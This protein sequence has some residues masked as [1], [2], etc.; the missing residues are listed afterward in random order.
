MLLE[1]IHFSDNFIQ[2]SRL[3]TRAPVSYRQMWWSNFILVLRFSWPMSNISPAYG[4]TTQRPKWQIQPSVMMNGSHG[5]ITT[6]TWVNGYGCSKSLSWP[7]NA[8][9]INCI[10][11]AMKELSFTVKTCIWGS[12]S[13]SMSWTPSSHTLFRT[14]DDTKWIHAAVL[15]SSVGDM[16]NVSFFCS[17]YSP[18]KGC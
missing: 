14:R 11:M 6:Y 16:G 8:R 4:F 18:Q 7:R 2:G 3:T 12:F 1:L 5:I 10:I 17:S 13:G 15:L 9:H